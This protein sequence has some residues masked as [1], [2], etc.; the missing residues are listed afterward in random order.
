MSYQ[1]LAS[2]AFTPG[3]EPTAFYMELFQYF[4]EFTV[5]NKGNR[6]DILLPDC[7]SK[8]NAAQR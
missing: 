8:Q 5:G 2:A 7:T 1:L 4:L 6:Q 3:K